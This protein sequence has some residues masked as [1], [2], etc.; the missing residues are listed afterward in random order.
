MSSSSADY[1][2]QTSDVRSRGQDGAIK[3][4]ALDSNPQM[5]EVFLATLQ[6]Y[7]IG[8]LHDAYGGDVR[9]SFA[10]SHLGRLMRPTKT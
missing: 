1:S 3:T 9:H 10:S 5:D 7:G 8:V 2:L 4:A 6:N